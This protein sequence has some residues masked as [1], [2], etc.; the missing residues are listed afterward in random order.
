MASSRT[1]VPSSASN[2]IPSMQNLM[3]RLWRDRWIY[4]FLMPTAIL[5]TLFTIWPIL[6]SYWYSL[7][8]WNGFERQ[9]TFIGLA[10]YREVMRD[11]WF[12]NSFKNTFLFMFVTLP[13]R[14]GLAFVAAVFLNNKRLPFSNLFRTM[15]FLPVVTTMAIVGVVMVFVFDPAGG[16]INLI[17]F[18]LNLIDRPIDFLGRSSTALYTAMGVHIWKWFGITLIYW[19]ASLQTVPEELYEAAQ[20][21]G[22]NAPQMFWYIT[23][24]M[25]IPFAII[26]VLITALDTLRVFDLILTL[27]GGGPAFRTEVVEVYIYRW[28]FAATIPRLGYASAA[29][30]F[31]GVATLFL[32]LGQA[33]GLRHAQRMRSR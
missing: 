24:P 11:P 31:F 27:T 33:A 3:H 12:W 15:L 2:Q 20:V 23:M 13:I 5:F 19:L 32:A 16:P 14:V 1:A 9:G 29:A 7:L 30:V 4:L 17:L 25:L 6:A 10:N 8:N 26:I 18:R 28:A 21:D 22:A